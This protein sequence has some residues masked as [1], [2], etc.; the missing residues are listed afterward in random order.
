MLT[1]A[2]KIAVFVVVALVMTA[3]LKL[4]QGEL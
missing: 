4:M 2:R 1:V 3:L